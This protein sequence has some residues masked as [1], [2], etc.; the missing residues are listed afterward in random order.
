MFPHTGST[1]TAARS[2]PCS[3]NT[4]STAFT[5]LKGATRVSATVPSGTPGEPGMPEG[6]HPGPGG[7]EQSVRMAVIAA[8]ELQDLPPPREASGHPER[9]HRGLGAGGHEADPLARRDEAHHPLGELYLGGAG[10]SV[11]GAALGGA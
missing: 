6:G 7:D 11:G 3:A 5:S 4:A 10:R 8:V 9:A 1:M 2:R